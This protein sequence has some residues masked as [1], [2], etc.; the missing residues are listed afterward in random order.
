MII[1]ICGIYQGEATVTKGVATL[2]R[3]GDVGMGCAVLTAEEFVCWWLCA[4]AAF[5]SYSEAP[6][7][8]THA[9]THTVYVGNYVRPWRLPD[10][11]IHPTNTYLSIFDPTHACHLHAGWR[12][13]VR[14]NH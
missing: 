13:R 1:I 12:G 8:H 14:R 9:H 7:T 11:F 4:A 5:R 6:H 10:P 3:Y 2:A